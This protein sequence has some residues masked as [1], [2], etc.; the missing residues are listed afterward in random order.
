M[1]EEKIYENFLNERL[2]AG[3]LMR[4][5]N[6]FLSKIPKIFYFSWLIKPFHADIEVTTKCN[7]KCKYCSIRHIPNLPEKNMKF[8]DFKKIID[9]L[10]TLLTVKLQGRGETFLEKDSLD[11]FSYLDKKKIVTSLYTNGT[12]LNDENIDA[13]LKSNVYSIYFSIEGEKKTHE[14][15]RTGSNY[16]LLV[17]NIKRLYKKRG[18]N[19]YPRIYFWSVINAYNYL[20]MK[21][22]IYVAKKL[23]VDKVFFQK[24]L[25]LSSYSKA[26]TE[27]KKLLV[28]KV[29]IEKTIKD[30]VLFAKENNICIEV[31]S[32]QKVPCNWPFSS[33]FI[34]CDGYILPCCLIESEK[35][36]HFGNIFKNSLNVIWKSPPYNQFRKMIRLKKYPPFC[37]ICGKNVDE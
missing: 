10:P 27:Q 20:K 14:A 5:F 11:M 32:D 18:N 22:L 19:P 16:D 25:Y 35:I 21:E 37:E 4:R 8:H 33:C 24:Q 34:T 23:K 2:K 6:Y 30:A 9:N 3:S 15:I 31:F 29:D 36:V 17:E 1:T 13:I 28:N 12:F 26:S 7:L